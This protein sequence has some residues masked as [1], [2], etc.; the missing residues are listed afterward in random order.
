MGARPPRVPPYAVCA[1]RGGAGPWPE[2][3][4]AAFRHC[5]DI[6]VEAVELDIHMTADGR[7]AVL[8]DPALDR[9]TTGRGPVA[10]KAAAE[11]SRLRLHGSDEAVPMLEDALD[12]LL[13]A[14]IEPWIEVKNRADGTAYPG[15]EARLCELLAAKG[16]LDRCTALA[17][18]WDLLARLRARAPN[19]RLAGNLDRLG[20]RGRGGAEACLARLAEIGA[21]TLSLDRRIADSRLVARAAAAGFAVALWTVNAE[22]EMRRWRAHPVALLITDHPEAALRV[23][24][25]AAPS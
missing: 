6:G 22:S 13:D 12:L 14:G 3:S 4:L 23:R 19:L 25:E 1:H 18:D 20:P 9:A 21:E 15:I 11:I 16:A 2:N 7:L 10:A 8:H 5:A 17:F 24:D